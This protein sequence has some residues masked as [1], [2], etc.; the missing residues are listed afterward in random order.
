ML[1][2]VKAKFSTYSY[3]SR[4][5][6]GSTTANEQLRRGTCACTST[7]KQELLATKVELETNS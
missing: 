1:Y 3:E 7:D 6:M 5:P 4:E 2:I